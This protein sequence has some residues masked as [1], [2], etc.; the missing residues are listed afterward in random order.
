M[1]S[2]LV[3]LAAALSIACAAEMQRPTAGK[4][5][6]L[7]SSELKPGMKATAWTVFEGSTPEAVPVE[8]VGLWKNAW[9]PKQDIILAKMGGKALRTGVAGGMSGSPVYVDGKLI[10]AVALR[11]SVFSPDAICGITPIELMLEI[12]D[13]DESRPA[14][15]K[16]PDKV[17]ARNAVEVPGELLAQAVAAGASGAFA[18]KVP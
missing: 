1:K 3:F 14:D 5:E 11:I 17:V 13:Y 8:I 2:S 18:N 4:V 10:G 12:N 15:S 7:K 16:S 9:G 6:I